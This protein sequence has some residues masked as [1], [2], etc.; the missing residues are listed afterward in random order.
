MRYPQRS[1]CGNGEHLL[2]CGSGLFRSRVRCPAQ[3]ECG[4]VVAGVPKWLP[5]PWASRTAAIARVWDGV[6]MT[7]PAVAI[8][9]N[10]ARSTQITRWPSGTR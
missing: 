6:G 7:G 2:F 5:T 10:P 3:I 9:P 4:D 8:S 1:T